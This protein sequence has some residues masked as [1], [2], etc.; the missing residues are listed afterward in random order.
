MTIDTKSPEFMEAMTAFLKEN[1]SVEFNTN[2]SY[3]DYGYGDYR[4]SVE[5]TMRV[6]LGDTLIT[7]DSVSFCTGKD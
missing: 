6:K 3:S 2:E 5:V 1:L 4:N 7:S